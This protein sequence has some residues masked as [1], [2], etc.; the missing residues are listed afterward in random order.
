[1]TPCEFGSSLFFEILIF[2]IIVIFIIGN[3]IFSFIYSKYDFENNEIILEIQNQLN[4]NFI[5]SFEQKDLCSE[6]EKPLILGK[7]DGTIE[8]CFCDNIVYKRKCNN[9]DKNCI[10]I[11]A[12]NPVDY[13]KINSKYICIKTLDNK[14]IDFIKNNQIRNKNIACPSGYQNCGLID[15][16][17]NVLCLEEG[18]NCPITFNSIII[19][20]HT[21]DDSFPLGYN[22]H[23]LDDNHKILGILQMNQY[24]PCIYPN[25]KNW[26]YYYTLESPSKICK[27]KVN[28]ILY[29]YQYQ[30]LLN[31]TK[32]Q[33]YIDNNIM[34]DL[35]GYNTEI[36]KNENIFLYGRLI[37]G[38]DIEKIKDYS[39]DN[40]VSYQKTSNRSNLALNIIS[41]IFIVLFLIFGFLISKDFYD[42]AKK[43]KEKKEKKKPFQFT[44][45][46]GYIFCALFLGIIIFLA[47]I[48]IIIISFVY[49][50]KIR[51]MINI[52]G[53]DKYAND[54]I[55]IVIK[56]VTKNFYFSLVLICL[57]GLSILLVIIFLIVYFIISC[58]SN[59]E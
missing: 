7:W 53:E 3:I 25:E 11:K 29:D 37:M 35:L 15:T 38:F 6:D 28:G 30:S 36:I 5:Y 16:V 45:G 51:A 43:K 41:Y 9:K 33:L 59:N 8:G 21:L 4:T 31:T 34:E 48:I 50:Y 24:F 23:Y 56:D 44:K 54:L 39:Y 1:M 46:L 17:G 27:T 10:A 14:Y 12:K 26:S 18:E 58:L 13:K 32:Y 57:I 49:S 19:H 47:Q 2:F 42:E 55:D 40:L 52:K 20:N 22:I